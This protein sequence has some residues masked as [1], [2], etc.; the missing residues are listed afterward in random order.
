MSK[1]LLS[2]RNASV[3]YVGKVKKTFSA[4]ELSGE[5]TTIYIKGSTAWLKKNNK[6]TQNIYKLSLTL[7]ILS[8]VLGLFNVLSG[9]PLAVGAVLLIVFTVVRAAHNKVGFTGPII[10]I[11]EARK[12]K[13]DGGTV[14]P[15]FSRY[16][17]TFELADGET[18][19]AVEVSELTLKSIRKVIKDMKISGLILTNNTFDFN[20]SAKMSIASTKRKDSVGVFKVDDSG[21][22]V[23]YWPSYRAYKAVFVAFIVAVVIWLI[24]FGG[25][26]M[27]SQGVMENALA[28]A[29]VTGTIIGALYLSLAGVLLISGG[30]PRFFGQVVAFM[31]VVSSDEARS[32]SL[33]VENRKGD[34]L[35]LVAEDFDI[36]NVI[37]LP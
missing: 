33:Y 31:P 4:W 14:E 17:V 20:Y 7:G 16:S 37:A 3:E 21:V 36:P 22:R 30:A 28:T 15:E 12:I 18:P 1:V 6:L 26:F 25:I 29:T 27:I 13:D 11:I 34:I 9:A 2:I 35:E 24:V 8:F 32:Y 5:Y 10:K 19:E 23:R